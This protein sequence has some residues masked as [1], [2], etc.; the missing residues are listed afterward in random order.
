[1]C[2]QLDA[3]NFK[4]IYKNRRK[5]TSDLRVHNVN[6]FFSKNRQIIP[7]LIGTRWWLYILFR[8]E[9]CL[10]QIF[11]NILRRLWKLIF[12]VG[13]SYHTK[14]DNSVLISVASC[15]LCCF[16]LI[17]LSLND[18]FAF[19]WFIELPGFSVFISLDSTCFIITTC[20][21]QSLC[22]FKTKLE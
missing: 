17:C 4:I 22:Q 18:H 6:E 15:C 7:L 5:S 8:S 13:A 11:T 16:L 10:I 1:M 14:C 20:I 12:F 21:C 3:A 2:T 9:M 19:P